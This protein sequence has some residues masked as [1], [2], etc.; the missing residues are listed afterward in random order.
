MR[1]VLAPS[2]SEHLLRTLRVAERSASASSRRSFQ[3]VFVCQNLRRSLSSC[4]SHLATMPASHVIRRCQRRDT[5]KVVP[6]GRRFKRERHQP[7]K[8]GRRATQAANRRRAMRSSNGA[9]LRRAWT[10]LTRRRDTRALNDV[11]PRGGARVAVARSRATPRTAA[12]LARDERAEPTVNHYTICN[13][14]VA[15]VM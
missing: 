14:T 12:R 10:Y 8:R 13:K 4:A 7:F 15:V 3:N 11:V 9:P 2:A 1:D 5:S 6:A